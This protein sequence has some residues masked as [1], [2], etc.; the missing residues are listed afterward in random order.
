MSETSEMVR[1]NFKKGDDIRDEGL[2]TPADIIRY[3][4]IV[5]GEDTK[6]QIMDVYRPKN[7]EGKVLPV[8]VSIHGGGWGY[9]DK[10]RYQY[11]CMSLAQTGF[12]VINFTYRLAP[13]FKFPAPIED[14][15][16]VFTWIL[17]HAR[18]YGLDT[19]NIFGVG[20][21]AGAHQLGLYAAMCTNK[22]YAMRFP[23]KI[24]EELTLRGIALNCGV[25]EIKL[26]G[27]SDPMMKDLMGDYLPG[28]GLPEELETINV[29]NH[30]T[31]KF[32][33]VYLMS[34]AGDFLLPEI[35]VMEAKLTEKRV[36]FEYHFYGDA[37][38]ELGHVFHCNMKLEEAH[39]CNKDECEFF[40]KLV[41]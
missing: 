26:E 25:Y 11:Y 40:K 41:K 10:E 22:E 7:A 34:A 21:S 12:A 4:D 19:N 15:N 18:G 8:I 24:P 31:E 33:P 20:D 1:M 5:Y 37:E 17:K 14:A 3:D 13:E 32:P 2:I 16:L 39:R 6:W 30:V 28:K 36:P 27:G 23:F 9:G 35:P 38:H 29:V